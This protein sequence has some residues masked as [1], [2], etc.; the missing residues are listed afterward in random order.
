MTTRSLRSSDGPYG[1]LE[2]DARHVSL[3][4]LQGTAPSMFA[5]IYFTIYFSLILQLKEVNVAK[6]VHSSCMHT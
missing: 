1:S 5:S 4:P 2:I 6:P 3:N